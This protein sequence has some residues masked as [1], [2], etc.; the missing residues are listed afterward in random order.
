MSSIISSVV[1]G[2]KTKAGKASAAALVA[3]SLSIGYLT[4]TSGPSEMT[5]TVAMSQPEGSRVKLRFTV[6]SGYVTESGKVL[7]CDNK[8]NR[9]PGCTTVVVDKATAGPEFA[10]LAPKSKTSSLNGKTFV[11]EGVRSSY[12]GKPQIQVSKVIR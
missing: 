2:L 6:G 3:A 11:F 8:D 12:N 10:G 9:T 1:S 5:P 7:L 4:A